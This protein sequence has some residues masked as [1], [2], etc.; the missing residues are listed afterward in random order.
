MLGGQ[1]AVLKA[2]TING[3]SL[4]LIALFDDG[5]GPFDVGVG[6]RHVVEAR[7]S[8]DDCNAR[9]PNQL[10]GS[11]TGRSQTV[12]LFVVP[13]DRKWGVSRQ[14]ASVVGYRSVERREVAGERSG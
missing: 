7:G 6:R 14:S 5:L 11:A 3:L 4:D 8:G 9:R 1:F 2:A 12:S 10:I 13:N